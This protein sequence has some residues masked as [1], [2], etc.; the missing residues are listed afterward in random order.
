VQIIA[1]EAE[2]I[3]GE[4]LLIFDDLGAYKERDEV[5]GFRRRLRLFLSAQV[6]PYVT[7]MQDTIDRLPAYSDWLA[8]SEEEEMSQKCDRLRGLLIDMMPNKP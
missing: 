6:E 7:H 4:L 5:L 8:A 3:I 2:T 1:R